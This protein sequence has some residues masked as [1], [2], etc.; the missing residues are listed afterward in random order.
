MFSIAIGLCGAVSVM[1]EQL[2]GFKYVSGRGVYEFVFESSLLRVSEFS[3]WA[4]LV[5]FAASVSTRLAYNLLGEN[6]RVRELPKEYWSRAR[7]ADLKSDLYPISGR[8]RLNFNSISLAPRIRFVVGAARKAVRRHEKLMPPSEASKNAVLQ[9]A[10]GLRRE[11]YRLTGIPPD[12][13]NYPIEFF[14]STSRALEVAL[15]RCTEAEQI[16]LSPYEH[17]IEGSVCR[18]LSGPRQRPTVLSLDAEA[19]FLDRGWNAQ[20]TRL[21]RLL[22]KAVKNRPSVL[23]LSEVHWAS[24]L[25]IPVEDLITAIRAE[26]RKADLTVIIDGAHCVGNGRCR[27]PIVAADAYVFGAHKWLMS[28]EPLGILIS[29]LGTGTVTR[30]YD[31][32][33]SSHEFCSIHV[34]ALAATEAALQMGT[35]VGWENLWGRSRDL[36]THFLSAISA[37]FDVVGDKS[38]LEHSLMLAIRPKKQYR[39]KSEPELAKRFAVAKVGLEVIRT[40][41]NEWVRIAFPY[42]F[43]IPEVNRLL[44]RLR[45]A[46][47]S[48]L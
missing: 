8:H 6:K 37:T 3:I 14:A 23:V 30:T 13:E 32:P 22:R 39:W 34:R 20:K 40:S 17:P 36:R 25:V 15:L 42:F 7:L 18:W 46:V 11:I 10:T 35:D 33:D 21:L 5:T 27:V 38:G 9:M 1:M 31:N 12:H 47:Q 19:D 43:D 41:Q 28:D 2:S 24:G 44:R 48:Q 45:E 4:V 26:H 16:I 29:N